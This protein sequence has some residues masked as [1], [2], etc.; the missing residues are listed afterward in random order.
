[1]QARWYVYE[2]LRNEAVVYVGK[3]CGKR[4]KQ[5]EKQRHGAA[6]LIAYF[7]HEEHAL[8]FERARILDRLS[9][10][11]R[12]EN[13]AYGNSASWWKRTD[14]RQMARDVLGI[15]AHRI[16]NWKRQNLLH[17]LSRISRIPQE[18]LLYIHQNFSI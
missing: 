10:G 16:G 11:C 14:T 15:L 9:D 3:G 18:Q 1:M 2:I 17:E 6:V 12:L 5:S 8:A 13:I 7:W 4:F